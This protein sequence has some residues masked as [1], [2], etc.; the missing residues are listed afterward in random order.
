ML[1]N[2]FMLLIGAWIGCLITAGVML[3]VT[4]NRSPT[5]LSKAEVRNLVRFGHL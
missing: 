2:I 1:F 4:A 5:Q 3:L